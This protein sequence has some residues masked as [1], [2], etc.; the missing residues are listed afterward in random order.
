MNP[1]LDS[2]AVLTA[3]IGHGHDKDGVL[4]LADEKWLSQSIFKEVKTRHC[5]N[6]SDFSLR[7]GHGHYEGFNDD[8]YSHFQ[9]YEDPDGFYFSGTPAERRGT[10]TPTYFD[11]DIL[12]GCGVTQKT[13]WFNLY[14]L[15][16]KATDELAKE[17]N[18]PAVQEEKKNRLN[19]F[20]D[21]IEERAIPFILDELPSIMVEYLG[22][23][24]TEI[25]DLM[26]HEIQTIYQLIFLLSD[27]KAG[28]GNGCFMW[29][30]NPLRQG[31]N[32]FP[33]PFFDLASGDS[34]VTFDFPLGACLRTGDLETGYDWLGDDNIVYLES[35]DQEGL[36]DWYLFHNIIEL[37]K[38]NKILP[39]RVD[40]RWQYVSIGK[41]YLNVSK[42]MKEVL[43]HGL[44]TISDDSFI[45]NCFAKEVTK[46]GVASINWKSLFHPDLSSLYNYYC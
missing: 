11:P 29:H 33:I 6:Y 22:H 9:G 14:Y 8:Y 30:L 1:I 13:L 35:V 5:M 45:N 3:N 34:G 43:T 18:K 41:H 42:I 46:K 15:I 19:V 44:K 39:L 12:N 26:K 31:R 21:L 23:P 2:V 17:I 20:H 36:A 16:D 4:I 28:V 40:C 10:N 7:C 37:F 38:A 27:H 25:I 24:L 32:Y